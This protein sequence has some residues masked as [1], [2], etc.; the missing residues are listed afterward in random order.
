M[1]V[2][3][4]SIHCLP[5][6]TLRLKNI[7]PVIRYETYSIFWLSAAENYPILWTLYL[8]DVYVFIQLVND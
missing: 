3:D 5:T 1:Y 2:S 7:S 8:T 4:L 6:Q